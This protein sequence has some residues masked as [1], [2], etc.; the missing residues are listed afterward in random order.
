MKKFT[1]LILFLI[2]GLSLKAQRFKAGLMAGVSTSQV[3]GDNLSGFDK[4]GVLI[5][6]LVNTKFSD[7]F[8]S[9]MELIFIQKGSKT[10][11]TAEDFYKIS[12]GYLEMPLLLRYHNKN[13][14]IEAGPSIG[15]L[16]SSNIENLYGPVTSEKPFNL[17]ETSINLGIN[18]PVYKNLKM[19]L[20]GNQSILPIRPHESG[21]TTFFNQGQYNSVLLFGLQYIF[22]PQNDK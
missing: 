17:V 13:L 6:G 4:A 1:V 22:D 9:E 21:A 7:K 18:Y 19:V 2:A 8:S 12:L 20:R 10:K 5:G 16:L 11:S 14:I 3:S 15:F